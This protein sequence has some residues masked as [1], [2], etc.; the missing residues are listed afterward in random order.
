M[1]FNSFYKEFTFQDFKSLLQKKLLYIK[2]L[3]Y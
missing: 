1:K 2:H 3:K